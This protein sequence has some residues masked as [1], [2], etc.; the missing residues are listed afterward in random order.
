MLLVL[1][2]PLFFALAQ[3]KCPPGTLQGLTDYDCYLL[4][5]H[6]LSWSSAEQQCTSKGGHLTSV[7]NTLVEVLFQSLVAAE[8]APAYWIGGY[9]EVVRGKGKWLWSDG[10]RWSY[11][12]W[13]KG[14]PASSSAN[15]N[16]V[17][18][19]ATSGLWFT[20]DCATSLPYICK[21]APVGGFVTGPPLPPLLPTIAQPTPPPRCPYRWFTL[22]S[23]NLCYRVVENQN[24][25]DKATQLCQNYNGQLVSIPSRDFQDD[26]QAAAWS[27][28]YD[29]N[30]CWI[31]LHQ[32]NVT[33]KYEWADG[34]PLT[35][36]NWENTHPD[37]TNPAVFMDMSLDAEWKTTTDDDQF[38]MIC[39]RAPYI[40]QN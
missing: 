20:S 17:S 2:L 38:Y 35:Y 33:K 24:T 6:S 8:I 32:N 27:T 23:S 28:C 16:C 12:N 4:N 14:Q 30:G 22:P 5:G 39:E 11:T 15:A 29:A 1:L 18:F 7:T 9:K 21:V 40:N 13:A 36:T 25:W 34:S 31:G 37:T 3:A 10:R 19:N 26:L